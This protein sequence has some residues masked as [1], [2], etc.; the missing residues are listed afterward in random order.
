SD[1]NAVPGGQDQHGPTSTNWKYAREAVGK[2]DCVVKAG[3]S[4]KNSSRCSQIARDDECI[5]DTVTVP[6][7]N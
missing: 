7:P 3:M 1:R 2:R 4:A 5:E 6:R